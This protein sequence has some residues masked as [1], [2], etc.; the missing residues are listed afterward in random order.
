MK[1]LIVHGSKMGGTAGIAD[2]LASTLHEEGMTAEVRAADEVEG[3]ESYD[4]VVIGG[5]LYASRWHRDARRFVRRHWAILEQRPVWLFSSGP[6]DDSA[7]D[8]AIPP[9]KMVSGL[10]DRVGA[11]GHA[12]FGGA[13]PPDAKGFP[14]SAMARE[15]AGDW[16][17]P[18]HIADWGHEIAA[19]LRSLETE[20]R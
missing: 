18:G 20:R 6:L 17:D 19:D 10:M 3:L 15:N 1:V 11:R 2:M 7:L 16:R 4:A 8:G 14:A 13:L 12:T 9:T 5:A